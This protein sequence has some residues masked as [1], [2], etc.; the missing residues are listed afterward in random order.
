[1]NSNVHV[2]RH[3]WYCFHS[4]YRNDVGPPHR[5]SDY[6]CVDY[7]GDASYVPKRWM[8]EKSRR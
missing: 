6:Y 2:G 7:D 5:E 8:D 1:M 3:R 4:N